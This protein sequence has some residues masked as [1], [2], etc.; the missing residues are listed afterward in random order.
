[1]VVSSEENTW[2]VERTLGDRAGKSIIFM[3][4]AYLNIWFFT[5]RGDV[6]YLS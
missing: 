1:M 3:M 6:V 2:A 4:E 5:G